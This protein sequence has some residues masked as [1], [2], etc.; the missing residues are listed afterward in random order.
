MSNSTLYDAIGPFT[1][2]PNA[3]VEHMEVIGVDA[4]ALFAY[5]RYR[6]HSKRG[7]AFPSYDRIRKDT[8]MSFRR[9]AGAIKTLMVYS[10]MSR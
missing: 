2:I 3:V 6:T 8:G 9:I 4:F 10:A 7:V 5:L 1:V